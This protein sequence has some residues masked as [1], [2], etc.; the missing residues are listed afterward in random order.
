LAAAFLIQGLPSPPLRPAV[1][2]E[3]T[4]EASEE[5]GL[6]P[7]TIVQVPLPTPLD[8]DLE[9]VPLDLNTILDPEES[10]PTFGSGGSPDALAQGEVL[11]ED[12]GCEYVDVFA[13]SQAAGTLKRDGILGGSRP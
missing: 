6:T 8:R 5:E 13:E 12:A 10:V 2:Q 4:P 9:P 11:E 1:A 3:A 7:E